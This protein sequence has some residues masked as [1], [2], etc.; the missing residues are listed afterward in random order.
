VIDE[1]DKTERI[2]REK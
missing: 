1:V 2:R